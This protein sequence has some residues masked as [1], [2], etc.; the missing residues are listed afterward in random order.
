VKEILDAAKRIREFI[1]N[2]KDDSE[3]KTICADLRDLYTAF[4]EGDEERLR[5]IVS[6]D[7]DVLKAVKLSQKLDTLRRQREKADALL[8]FCTDALK[9]ALAAKGFRL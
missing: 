9:L 7:P 6:V 5:H 1:D 2:H 3:V 4:A 8:Q